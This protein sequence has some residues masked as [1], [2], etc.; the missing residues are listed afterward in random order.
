MTS[1]FLDWLFTFLPSFNP[2]E[3]E[4]EK[5][6]EQ[7]RANGWSCVK[8]EKEKGNYKGKEGEW[9]VKREMTKSGL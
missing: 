5:K 4:V 2:N 9:G 3:C 7:E 1:K 6:S 8:I